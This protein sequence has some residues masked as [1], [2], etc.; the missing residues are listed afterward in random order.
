MNDFY[1]G[2]FDILVCTTIIETGIDIPNAN[3]ILINNA[4][5]FGLAQLHQLRGRVGRSHH[6]AY[7]YL[8]IKSKYALNASAKKR[9]DAIESLEELGAGFMLANHDLEIRGAGNLLGDN[10]SG[11]INEIGFNLYHD[12]LKRTIESIRMGQKI[13]L[14]EAINSE[15]EIDI[16]IST[17]IPEDFLPDIHE[18]LLVYKRVASCENSSELDELQIEFI[19]RYGL[20]PDSMIQLFAVNELKLQCKEHHVRK[21]DVY[22]DKCIIN[23]SRTNEINIEIIIKLVQTEPNIY[24]LKGDSTLIIKSY[25]GQG[26]KRKNI[27]SSFLSKIID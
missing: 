18:R 23:F 13:D 14:D 5:N 9:L 11:K 10:Q 19:D 4:Q 27:I 25:M 24:N 16:G 12:L 15:P 6:L 22:D 17:V 21:L 7:A 26:I 1:H 20:L 2:R 8:I 3:T